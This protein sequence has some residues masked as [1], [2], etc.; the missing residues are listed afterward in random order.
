MTNDKFESEINTL[1]KFYGLYCRDKHTNQESKLELLNYKNQKYF[2]E[3]NLCN[4]VL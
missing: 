2:L 4:G 1:K 3:L